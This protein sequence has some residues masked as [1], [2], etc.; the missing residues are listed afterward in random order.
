MAIRSSIS[1]L[2]FALLSGASAPVGAVDA[3]APPQP[4]TPSARCAGCHVDA[5][6]SAPAYAPPPSA[7]DVRQPGHARRDRERVPDGTR[8]RT[9]PFYT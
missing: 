3:G 2:V 7:A 5:R 1:A 4:A 8:D 9:E 6:G